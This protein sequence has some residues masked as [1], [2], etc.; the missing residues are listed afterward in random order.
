MPYAVVNTPGGP[1][2]APPGGVIERVLTHVI[3][4][5]S[6]APVV[7]AGGRYHRFMAVL[8]EVVTAD[9]VSG[10]GE[11]IARGS[12]DMVRAAVDSLLAPMVVGRNI[13]AV[14]ATHDHMLQRMRRFGHAAGVVIEAI[15][16]VDM[17]IWDAIGRATGQPLFS[18]LRG[19]GRASLRCYASSVFIQPVADMCAE[20]R[21]F[22]AQGFPMVKVKVGRNTAQGG[23][24]ADINAVQAIREALPAS[25]SISIDANSA[26]N[27][28]EAVRLAAALEP[29][30]L[31]F[32]EEPVAPDDLTGYERVRS[33]TRIPL[34]AG[35]S[36][37]SIWTYRDLLAGR[38][39]DIVQP[40]L[41]RCGGV[42]GA[43]SIAKMGYAFDIPV[44]PHTGFS[45]G[46]SQLA[47]IQVAA[48]IP[49]LH[50]LEHMCIDNPLKELFTTPFPKPEQGNL[51]VPVGAGLGL[52]VDRARVSDLKGFR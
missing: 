47:A 12:P 11:S 52:D 46:V 17:A 1:W 7:F 27:P 48:A 21:D 38:L 13:H 4:A 45:S 16:G 6:V 33:S 29:L 41:G 25:V 2:G 31:T 5:D 22:A 35:E 34:A 42:T 23:L 30:D 8:V 15:S 9:G 39:V 14:E 44:A 24:R 28:S 3:S 18:L 37:F 36:A 43:V 19:V 51:P 49:N 20:A 50:M 40:D 10:F 32:F 26:Y